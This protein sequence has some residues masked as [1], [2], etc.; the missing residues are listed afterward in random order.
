[1]KDPGLLYLP[2]RPA[3]SQA[4]AQAPLPGCC[5]LLPGHHQ[6]PPVRPPDRRNHRQQP[7]SHLDSPRLR[8]GRVVSFIIILSRIPSP[9]HH[10]LSYRRH[11]LLSD[12]FFMLT[13]RGKCPCRYRH[14]VPCLRLRPCLYRSFNNPLLHLRRK[15]KPLHTCRDHLQTR[16]STVMRGGCLAPTALPSLHLA[17]RAPI[18]QRAHSR[19]TLHKPQLTQS[20]MF[21]K[22]QR[23]KDPHPPVELEGRKV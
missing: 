3:S 19:K 1:M 21:L 12:H 15:Y 18:L 17:R 8:E 5:S 6:S 11:R 2:Q 10:P 13:G 9:K 7:Q 22:R 14:I 16:L 23:R 20:R 4:Q